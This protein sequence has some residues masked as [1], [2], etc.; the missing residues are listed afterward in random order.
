MKFS[1]VNDI[2]NIV[3]PNGEMPEYV[4]LFSTDGAFLFFNII[5]CLVNIYLCSIYL[6]RTVVLIHSTSNSFFF[7]FDVRL[8]HQTTYSDEEN[9]YFQVLSWVITKLETKSTDTY[10]IRTLNKNGLIKN[11]NV[12]I[13]IRHSGK[14]LVT[15][16]VSHHLHKTQ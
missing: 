13:F 15:L 1:L 2:I 9:N 8:S 16:N 7:I 4:F 6:R 5:L 14:I 10:S 12:N 11:I 3:I